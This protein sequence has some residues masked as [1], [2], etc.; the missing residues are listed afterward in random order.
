MNEIQPHQHPNARED[1][2]AERENQEM[3]LQWTISDALL[4]AIGTLV[5]HPGDFATVTAA[6]SRVVRFTHQ[7]DPTS[8]SDLYA[9][10]ALT[11]YVFDRIVQLADE[12]HELTTSDLQGAVGAIAL[13][14]I[15]N[16]ISG[17]PGRTAPEDEGGG[18]E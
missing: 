13:R 18:H 10:A 14:L 15:R 3:E 17:D 8:E 11:N 16:E 6:A 4:A 7:F 1:D 2:A 12:Y 5:K 9:A